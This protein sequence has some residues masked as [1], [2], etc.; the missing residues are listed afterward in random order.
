MLT[1]FI[2]EKLAFVST[3]I[4]LRT[5]MDFNLVCMKIWPDNLVKISSKCMIIFLDHLLN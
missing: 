5:Q 4:S 1:L 3:L 2:K